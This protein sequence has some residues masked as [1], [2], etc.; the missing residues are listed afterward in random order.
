MKKT[1]DDFARELTCTY[2]GETYSVRDNGAV[3]CH[4]R[5]DGRKQVAGRG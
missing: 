3:R 1:I 4:P 5:E 2:K